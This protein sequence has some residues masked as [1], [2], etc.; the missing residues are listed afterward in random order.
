MKNQTTMKKQI[1]STLS[2][3]LI[4][5]C[6]MLTFGQGSISLT[7]TGIDSSDYLQLDSIKVKNLTQDCDTVLYYPDTV[8]TI[9]NVGI[10]DIDGHQDGFRIMQNYPNPSVDA[11]YVRVL[12]PQKG[13]VKINITD[14]SG[15]RLLS[16]DR[17]MYKGVNTVRLTLPGEGIYLFNACWNN[18]SNTV[19]I[20]SVYTGPQRSCLIEDAGSTQIEAR[21][22]SI[23]AAT[24]F[25]FSPG[26]ELMLIGYADTLESGFLDS[27]ETSQ[28]YVFQ[29]AANI[30][31]PGLDS[32]LYDGQWYHTIQVFSQC[33]IKENMNAG[34]MILSGQDQTDNDLVEKYCMGDVGSYCDLLGGLYFWDEM[35][36]YTNETGG[37][38]ICPDGF[39][40]PT[41]LEW[42][43]L[44]G[45]ADSEYMIGSPAWKVNGWRGT[46]AGGNLK[47]AGTEL[48]EYPNTGATDAFGFSVIPAGYFVQGGF[49][50][51][52]YKAYIWSSNNAWMYFRNFDW[53]QAKVQRGTGGNEIAISVRCIKD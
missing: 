36:N 4:S 8:L 30:P 31:C 19:R 41:D 53:N 32:L 49:W 18:T 12:V 47:Q 6:L 28:D 38:G 46:D 21:P 17:M 16:S 25:L 15:R 13:L 42:Q 27:P 5:G 20:V 10:H 51:P 43:I 52:G 14:A 9:Y 7:F 24:D 2:T 23:S 3:I 50:G 34:T 29:F 22:K 33:W 40:V 39:H 26:D 48:W 1:I 11:T 45:A 35:M 44:E 37:Q